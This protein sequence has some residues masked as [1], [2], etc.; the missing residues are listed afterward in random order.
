[1]MNK[2]ANILQRFIQ[3][4]QLD[5]IPPLPAALPLPAVESYSSMFPDQEVPSDIFPAT[6]QLLQATPFYN[7]LSQARGGGEVTE[8]QV[9]ALLRETLEEME[10]K[11]QEF[12]HLMLTDIKQEIKTESVTDSE[13]FSPGLGQ[14]PYI[15]GPE[16]FWT[17][18]EKN[19]I[20]RLLIE[21]TTACKTCCPVR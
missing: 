5:Q 20:D 2:Q 17:I 13:F 11:Q 12:N 18:E 3:D 8:L 6:D 1:M 7:S 19:I 10:E 4:G 16:M 14:A 21:Q 9:D 15:R